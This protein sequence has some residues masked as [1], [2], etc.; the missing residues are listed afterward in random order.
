MNMRSAT[1]AGGFPIMLFAG[2]MLVATN[3]RAPFTGVAPL[4]VAIQQSL[5]INS[6]TAGLLITLPL[7]VFMLVSP[8]VPAVSRRFGIER[9]LFLSLVLIA[10]GILVRSIGGLTG[11]FAGTLLIGA[12][13]AAGNVMLPSVVKLRFPHHIALLTSSY[14]LAMG[15]M[16]AAWSAII[17]PLADGGAQ[18]QFALLTMVALPVLSALLWLNQLKGKAKQAPVAHEQHSA[19][20]IFS[21]RLTWQICGFFGCNAFLYYSVVSWLPAIV[22]EAGFSDAQAG[23]IHGIFQFA[24][25]LPGLVI[26]PA[27]AR[28]NDQRGLSVFMTAVNL[29]GFAGIMLLPQL[30]YVWAALLG[31]AVGAN[32]ILALS[33][34][35]L[36]TRNGGQAASL[37]SAA[38]TTGYCVAASGPFLLGAMYDWVGQWQLALIVCVIFSVCQALLGLKVGRNIQLPDTT[39]PVA[40]N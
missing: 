15:I 5:G 24:S 6:S 38:Q 27:M 28:L 10:V 19:K 26:V 12:G 17:I 39:S 4:M 1:I 22:G 21:H 18:W 37:S 40:G 30:A 13:I 35:G 33:F 31:F 36:R 11:L 7:L 3:L 20:A 34:I 32:F 8:L 16:A 2:V 23:T 14:V 29:L 25:A 9:T